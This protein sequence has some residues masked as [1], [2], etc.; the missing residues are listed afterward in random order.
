[1]SRERYCFAVDRGSLA[2]PAVEAF[3]S[4]L[5]SPQFRERAAALPGYEPRDSGEILP[6]ESLVRAE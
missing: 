1:M 6:V 4:A 3:I 5:R 2:S